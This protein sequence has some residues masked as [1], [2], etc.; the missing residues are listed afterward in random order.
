M[1]SFI[2]LSVLLLT[3]KLLISQT[4]ITLDLTNMPIPSGTYN[5]LRNSIV[6]PPSPTAFENQNW[7]YSSFDGPNMATSQWVLETD[8]F[9]TNYGIDCYGSFFKELSPALGLGYN[10]DSELDFNETGVYEKGIYVAQ[11]SYS[12]GALTGN[13]ADNITF[14][15]QGYILDNPRKVMQFPMTMNSHWESVSKRTNN[16]TLK[17]AAYGLNN[18]PGAHVCEFFRKDSI[19][20]WGTL[21]VHTSAGSSIPYPVLVDQVKQYS[22]DSFYLG[23]APA[24]TA[25]LNAFSVTQGQKADQGYVYNFYREGFFTY[26]MR[27]D[28]RGDTTFTN[29][30]RSY[31]HTDDLATS[32]V[33]ESIG[34]EYSTVLFP[35]P[36][37][38]ENIQLMIQGKAIDQVSYFITDYSG[39]IVQSAQQQPLAGNTL[40]INMTSE[41][42]AGVY[43]L[44]VQDA[45]NATIAVEQIRVQR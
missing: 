29:I 19:V 35:N 25:I 16:F 1:K 13:T 8:P 2:T 45:S 24:P 9:Y 7:D 14:P 31:V 12:L 26:L 30:N 41:L 11:Q 21:R 33:G 38:G 15:V 27:L 37:N 44:S 43:V 34:Y 28:Y 36:S 3:S 6:N 39:R 40:P 23:G 4:A 17:V 18:V 42:P 10:T 5:Y 22:L 20:G 32:G